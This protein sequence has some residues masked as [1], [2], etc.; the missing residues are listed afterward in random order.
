MRDRYDFSNAVIGKYIGRIRH[1]QAPDDVPIKRSLAS[2]EWRHPS[3]RLIAGD[4]NPVDVVVEKAREIVLAAVD[5]QAVTL[6]IDPFKLAERLS[7]KITARPDVRD[8]RTICGTD[9]KLVIEYNPSRPL[10]RIRFSLCHELA[11]TLFPDCAEQVRNRSLHE[12]MS[13]NGYEL[14]MLCNLAAAEFLLPLGSVQEDMS[15]CPWSIDTALELREKY[16]ASTEAVLLRLAGLAG[17][18]CAVFAAIPEEDSLSGKR[19]HKLE[20]VKTAHNWDV[21]LKR[22]DFLPEVTAARDITAI[23]YTT[24]S[25]EEWVAGR[26]KFCV[27]MVGA[28][29]YPNRILPRIVG[30]IRPPGVHAIEAPPLIRVRGNALKPRGTGKKIVAHVVNDKTPNWGAGFGK[31]LQTQWPGAQQGFK[32]KFELMNGPRLGNT[33]FTA[34]SADVIAFQMICQHG[35]GQSPTPRLKYG[36]L[37]KCLEALQ[38][39]AKREGATVHMPRIGAGQAGGTWELI[40]NLITEELCNRGISVTVYELPGEK[41]ESKQQIDLFQKR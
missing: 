32:R 35:Y 8:A 20:Y 13:G 2:R 6:P 14:E 12:D 24:K 25:S 16:K 9:Q 31:A 28:S 23:G 18:N 40:E 15:R 10:N 1:Y 37:R 5:E 7:I 27:E 30:L 11:H 17:S 3:V 21:G 34:V 29:P 38:S 22:G 39:F 26:G 19:R 33:A 36:A 4:R 41:T